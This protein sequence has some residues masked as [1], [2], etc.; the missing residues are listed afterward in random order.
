MPL[1]T[2]EQIR[3]TRETHIYVFGD[4]LR[5]AGRGGQAAICRGEPN[6]YGVPTKKAP[7]NR[8]ESFFTDDELEMNKADIDTA[9]S[10]IPNDGRLVVVFPNIGRGLSE[11]PRR[12]PKTLEYLEQALR[13]FQQRRRTDASKNP[14][15]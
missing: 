1:I 4:N 6:C 15:S 9:L 11:M 5:C 8:P 12:C 13:D 2:L 7:D 3:S 10:W 14:K